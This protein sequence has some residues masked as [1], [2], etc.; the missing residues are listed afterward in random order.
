MAHRPKPQLSDFGTSRNDKGSYLAA[1]RTWEKEH[2][3]G[4]TEVES[5]S[6]TENNDNAD[7]KW[8]TDQLNRR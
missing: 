5:N 4:I 8:L 1:L 6:D 3:D 7:K 2:K